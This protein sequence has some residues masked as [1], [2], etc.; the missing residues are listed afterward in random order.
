MRPFSLIVPNDL[1][2]ASTRSA[3]NDSELKAAGMDVLDRLKERVFPPANV[4][5]LLPLRAELS[6]IDVEASG[7]RIGA[8]TTLTQVNQAQALSDPAYRALSFAAGD[9]ATPLVRN[10]ATI[11]GNIIQVNRCWY[12]RSGAPE[13]TCAHQ[14]GDNCLAMFG[15]NR[16]HAIM[17]TSTC[18]RVH[19]SNLAP[20]LMVL[21]AEIAV[22]KDG[23]TRNVP[24]RDLYPSNPSAANSEHTLQPGEIITAIFVPAQPE[25]T[26]SAYVAA[27]EKQSFDWPLTAAA[28]RLTMNGNTISDAAICLGSVAPNPFPRDDAAQSLKGKQATEEV[29][30]EAAEAAIK[31][32]QPLAHNE[33]KIA[34]GKATLVDALL[35]AA[36]R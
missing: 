18:F 30:L 1:A 8:L 28:A 14:G 25:G 17:G 27:R 4:V 22:Y 10:R 5:S 26:G 3:A 31:E 13:F 20:P 33:Y 24:I 34:L 6:G 23:Q 2:E 19:P 12:Y 35:E 7:V 29:F 16:Y 11:A 36:R 15:E 32:A 9:A 21:D